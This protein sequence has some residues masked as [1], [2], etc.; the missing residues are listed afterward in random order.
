MRIMQHLAKVLQE[1]GI[2]FIGKWVKYAICSIFKNNL[3]CK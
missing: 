1:S 3:S 2:K